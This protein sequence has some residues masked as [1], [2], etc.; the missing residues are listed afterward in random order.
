VDAGDPALFAALLKQARYYTAPLDDTEIGGVRVPGYRPA[1]VA[2]C[3][4]LR[5]TLGPALQIEALGFP[6]V[7]DYQAARGLVV[8]GLIGPK[9]RAALAAESAP[10]PFA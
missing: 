3:A 9:T 8:D 5:R 2:K 6:S 7:S 10:D 1:M 4:A